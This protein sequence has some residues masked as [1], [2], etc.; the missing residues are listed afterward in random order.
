[1]TTVD[2]S[3]PSAQSDSEDRA[4]RLTPEILEAQ[5]A[6]WL[7]N[8]LVELL[9]LDAG[10]VSGSATFERYGLDSSAAVGMTGDLSEWLGS[11]VDAA[12]TF[13]HPSIDKLAHAL[14]TDRQVYAAF[15]RKHGLAV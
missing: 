13:D 12:A 5:I 10:G 1:M 7:K 11:E 9:G 6:T 4:A 8:Y 3:Q 2:V 14:A 15:A